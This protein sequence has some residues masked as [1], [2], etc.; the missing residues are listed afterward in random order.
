M[1]GI[2]LLYKADPAPEKV[3]IVVGAYRSDDGIPYVF[4]V[5]RRAEKELALDHSLNKEYLAIDGLADFNRMAQELLFGAEN[6]LV[7]SKKIVTVQCPA[8]TGCLRIGFEFL[9]YH[10]PAEVFVSKP[11]WSNHISIIH[12]SGL[13]T[14]EYPYYNPTTKA[15]NL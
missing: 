5:V 14:T 4:D 9:R 2:D 12:A 1:F 7:K 3:D 10:L 8:G 6:P 11:T 15:F 13:K